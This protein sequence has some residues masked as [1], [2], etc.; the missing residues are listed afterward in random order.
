MQEVVKITHTRRL[1]ILIKTGH[2]NASQLLIFCIHRGH[3]LNYCICIIGKLLRL[4]RL[5]LIVRV[6]SL[7]HVACAKVFVNITGSSYVAISL[8]DFDIIEIV[9]FRVI[10]IT[11][12]IFLRVLL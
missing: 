2:F 8:P 12:A 10:T 3:L 11:I 5:T 7:M 4:N 6:I 9:E 1:L